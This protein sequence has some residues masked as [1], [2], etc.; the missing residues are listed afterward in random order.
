MARVLKSIDLGSLPAIV[1]EIEDALV[2]GVPIILRDGNR[3]I[4]V[5]EPLPVESRIGKPLTPEEKER[6]LSS[7]GS[8]KDNVDTDR[9]L[10]DIYASRGRPMEPEEE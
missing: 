9:L 7:A 4:A 2:E 5:V 6:F 8:W 1:R 3:E 10:R